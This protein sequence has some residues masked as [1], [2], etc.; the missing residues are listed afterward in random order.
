MKSKFEQFIKDDIKERQERI[1]D[2]KQQLD[3]MPT[4]PNDNEVQEGMMIQW[5]I[6][7]WTR[8]VSQ[9]EIYIAVCVKADAQTLDSR[10]VVSGHEGWY[11][12]N[13]LLRLLFS[14][15]NVVATKVSKIEPWPSGA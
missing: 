9:Q 5:W 11:G 4:L 7:W 12:Y 10:W 8:A 6:Q 3:L 14:K 15:G 13:E 1:N 2:L